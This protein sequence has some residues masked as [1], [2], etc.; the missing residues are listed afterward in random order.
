MV[1]GRVPGERG[2]SYGRMVLNL[3]P[4]TAQPFPFDVD[5]AI[6]G[7]TENMKEGMFIHLKTKSSDGSF[8][9][10]HTD[11][12]LFAIVSFKCS[13]SI[14]TFSIRFP[15]ASGFSRCAFIVS[16]CV[17][18]SG[19]RPIVSPDLAGPAPGSAINFQFTIKTKNK[20]KIQIFM[21]FVCTLFI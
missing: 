5:E 12:S 7:K 10:I 17:K 18:R 13:N 16:N 1:A 8:S 6:L 9:P 14:R 19:L 2:L 15:R 11:P 21:Q 20:K 4:E 3:F